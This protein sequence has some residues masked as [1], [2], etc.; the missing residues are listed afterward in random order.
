MKRILHI[1]A[2]FGIVLPMFA[3]CKTILE[4]FDSDEAVASVGSAKLKKV[5]L[6]KTTEQSGGQISGGPKQ[7]S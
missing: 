2:L 6:E 7:L 1:V 4:F 5:D 3:S